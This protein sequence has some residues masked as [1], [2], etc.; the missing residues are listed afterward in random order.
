MSDIH[1]TRMAPRDID[2]VIAIDTVAYPNPWSAATWR[3]ELAAAERLHMVAL[4]GAR[5]VG[6]AGL[7]YV[8]D[9]VHITT[10]ATA[11]DR[12]SEGIATALL[13]RLLTAARD[14]GAT[15]AT[16]EVRSGSARPQRLYGRFGFRP[17]GVRRKYYQDPIDDGIVMWLHDLD[18]EDVAR[19]L[20]DL[21]SGDLA[22]EGQ[23]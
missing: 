17:A 4:D 23:T 1:Y 16:L 18:S 14:H 13:V 19:R 9:E 10:V 7:L 2:A 3:K 11:E 12:A 20:A 5:V 21:S 15:A 6:H 8:L 22:A